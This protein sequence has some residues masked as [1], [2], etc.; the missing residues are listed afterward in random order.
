MFTPYC[1]RVQA[2]F[3]V[4]REHLRQIYEWEFEVPPAERPRRP[5][6][7]SRIAALAIAL[8][9]RLTASPFMRRKE[10]IR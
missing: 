10:A 2:L 1:L 8:H 9:N 4:H 7:G 5:G 3:A 6:P